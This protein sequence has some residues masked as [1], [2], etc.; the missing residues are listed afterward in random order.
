ME[1]SIIFFIFLN[2]GFPY[3]NIKVSYP[4][5]IAE[6]QQIDKAIAIG[7]TSLST[8]VKGDVTHVWDHDHRI[9]G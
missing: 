2:E 5:L 6:K 1:F 3:I 4:I 9:S 7:K 8:G